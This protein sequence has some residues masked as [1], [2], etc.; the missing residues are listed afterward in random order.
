MKKTAVQKIF[1]IHTNENVAV[2]NYVTVDIDFVMLH[3][4]SAPL[5]RKIFQDMN[6]ERFFDAKKVAMMFDH[7]APCP[8]REIANQQKLAR[9][10]AA[11]QEI[12]MFDVGSGI[13]H[14]IMIEQGFARNGQ[15]V[16]GADSHCCTY[17]AKGAF[18]L[19]LGPT[20]ICGILITGK[21]WMKIPPSIRV[22][23][24]GKLSDGTTAKDAILTLIGQLGCC[25]ATYRA[26]EFYDPENALTQD[27]RITICNMAIEMEAKAGFFPEGTFIADPGAEYFAQYEIDLGKIVPCVSKPHTVENVHSIT[28]VVGTPINHI[29]F[30]S[31]TNGRYSDLKI[32]AEILKGKKIAP[33][34]QFMITPASRGIYVQAMRDGIMDILVEAGA[35]VLVPGCGPCL[36]SVGAIPADGDKVLSTS[37]RNY[38]GRMANRN[39]EIYLCSPATAA[40]SALTGKIEDPRGVYRRAENR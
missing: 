10:F 34:V 28:E 40:A 4:G 25:G 13:G 1:S 5:V 12:A 9:N 24:T 29:L 33:N 2:G 6:G 17:G 35:M 39:A 11:E 30:G 23:F 21:T 8:N 26:I 20:D 27:E 18:S 15:I 14:Q 38:Y 36:G 37:N 3:D 31:C 7:S 16:V 19:G 22:D 32:A